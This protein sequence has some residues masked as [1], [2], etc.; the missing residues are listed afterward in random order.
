MNIQSELRALAPSALIELFVLDA[1]AQGGPNYYFHSG[2]SS[3]MREV[4]WQGVAYTPVPMEAIDFET[5]SNGAMPSPRI[6][7]A[8]LQGMIAAAAREYNAFAGCRIIRKRTFARFLDAVNFP[9]GNPEADPNQFLPD[10][11]WYVDRKSHEDRDF[12]E[13]ELV[14]A[15]DL[16]GIK[17]PRRQ[18][19][20]T[21]TRVYRGVECGYTGGPV[22]DEHN[23]PTSDIT[24]DQ[25]SKL[26][27]GCK[28]RF[29]N[30][31]LPFGGFPGAGMM[32]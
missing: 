28:L 29:G 6:R 24:K 17:L 16:R 12:L 31:P 10:D 25:C 15:M 20:T 13:F 5:K 21:C 2:V 3:N 30:G 27:T 1:G 23:V 26:R 4:V 8:N 14:T 11:I 32:R 7:I 22:A 19:L 18:I 9:D